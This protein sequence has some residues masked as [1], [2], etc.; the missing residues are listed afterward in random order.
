MEKYRK[1]EWILYPASLFWIFVGVY[2]FHIYLFE[3]ASQLLFIP[4]GIILVFLSIVYAYKEYLKE[5]P[6]VRG[7]D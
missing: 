2:L 3:N 7:Q 4:Y 1:I 6:N 5:H